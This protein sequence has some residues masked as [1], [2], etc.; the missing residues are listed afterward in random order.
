MYCKCKGIICSSEQIKHR[1]YKRIPKKIM[2]IHMKHLK[3]G[4][5]QTLLPYFKREN[6]PK[7]KLIFDLQ[8][9][10]ILIVSYTQKNTGKICIVVRLHFPV[11]DCIKK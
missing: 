1:Q 9:C 5:K 7:S 6:N 11:I 8:I 3:I 2:C 4:N 10:A